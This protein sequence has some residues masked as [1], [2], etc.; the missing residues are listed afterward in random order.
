MY[1]ATWW[2]IVFG[3]D[4]W[5]FEILAGWAVTQPLCWLLFNLRISGKLSENVCFIYL[6]QIRKNRLWDIISIRFFNFPWFEKTSYCRASAFSSNRNVVSKMLSSETNERNV[7][8]I[9][10]VDFSIVSATP[11]FWPKRTYRNSCL[12]IRGRN[13]F[14]LERR[15]LVNFILVML[16][17]ISG[18]TYQ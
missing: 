3:W 2:Y 11:W 7:N 9:L 8:S 1:D 13:D 18:M 6:H 12:L 4:V 14:G 17:C 15:L 5:L 10:Q 16:F